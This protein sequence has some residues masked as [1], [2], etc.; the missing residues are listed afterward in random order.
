MCVC[1]VFMAINCYKR[2]GGSI[3]VKGGRK[4]F[5]REEIIKNEEKLRVVHE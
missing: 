2:V 1:W 4:I 3:V 5:F